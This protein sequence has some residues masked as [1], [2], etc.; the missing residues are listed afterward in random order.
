[1]GHDKQRGV[2]FINDL[3][4]GKVYVGSTENKNKR[5]SAH[6]RMLE[7]NKHHNRHLQNSFN[8]G[9]QFENTFL[10]LDSHVDIRRVEKV[11]IDNLK[12]HGVLLNVSMDTTAPMFGRKHSSETRERMSNLLLGNQRTLGYVQTEEHKI[13][14]VV[15]RS[16]YQ[17]SKE[18]KEKISSAQKGKPGKPMSA[19]AK[20]KIRQAN[21]GHTRN[22]GRTHSADTKEKL[23][24]L[25]TGRTHVVS[26]E[27]REVMRQAK[28]GKSLSVEHR[29]KLSLAGMGRVDSEET[30]HKKHLANLHKAKSVVIEGVE[31]AS[32]GV[33]AKALGV[34]TTTI[35]N[36]INSGWYPNNE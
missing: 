8:K 11:L 16:G 31:Y 6:K 33:A 36:R 4:S 26:E 28:L 17:H 29:E 7:Q 25:S 27:A 30:K 3:D 35:T 12:S 1:M 22:L 19:E 9:H 24:M 23:R 14:S 34:T 10:P 15:G 13:N 5:D 21:L 18:T 32:R 20:E 2:Y